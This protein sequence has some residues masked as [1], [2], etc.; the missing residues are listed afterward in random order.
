MFIAKKALHRRT[1]LRGMGVTMALP[2]LD[3]MVPALTAAAQSP[4]RPVRR[5]GAIYMPHGNIMSQ[6]TPT[7]AGPGFEFTTILKPLEAYRDRLT[8]VSGMTSGPTAPNGGHAVAP[9]SYLTG[10]IQPKQTEGAD[11]L[12]STTIDQVIAKA[13]GQDTRFPSLEVATED[14]STSIGACDTGYSCSYMNT[15]SWSGPTTPQPMEVNPRAVF[16]RMF[17]SAGTPEQRRA[18][19]EEDRSILDSITQAAR[20]LQATLGGN[21]RARVTDYLDSVREIERRIQQAERTAQTDLVSVTA[22]VGAPAE[23]D[24]HVA[25]HYDLLVAAFQADIT[26]VF[27]FMMARDVSNISFPQIGVPDPHHALSHDANRGGDAVKLA[28]FVKVNTHCVALFSRFVEKLRN[29]RD[30]NGTLLDNSIV[31]YGS[32]MANGNDHTH[33]PLPLVLLGGGSGEMKKTGHHLVYPER[34]PMA[35]LLVTLAQKT[36]TPLEQFGRSTETIDL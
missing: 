33:H 28:K 30:G 9:A 31:L 15:I 18:Y 25:I 26:R 7:T 29:T 32:G 17:G 12:A 21:D 10:N 5:F 36:G 19:L 1:F 27:T 24:E 3:A 4:A 23:Y 2:L 11:I 13:I 16:E 20:G 8:L 34:Y 22:P 14:F 6:W 35:N